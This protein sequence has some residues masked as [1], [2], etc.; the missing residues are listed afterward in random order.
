M[1]DQQPILLFL[2]WLLF[3]KNMRG[4]FLV[5]GTISLKKEEYI[6]GF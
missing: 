4:I 5:W 6:L 2:H 1:V 3:Y